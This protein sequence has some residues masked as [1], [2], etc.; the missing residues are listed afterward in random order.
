MPR[1]PSHLASLP[2]KVVF[3]EPCSPES[4]TTVGRCGD[5]ARV[6]GERPRSLIRGEALQHLLAHGPGLDLGDKVFRH[7]HLDVGLEQRSA[8]LTQALPDVVRAQTAL[9]SQVAEDA[10]EPARERFEHR[11]P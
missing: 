5:P 7:R 2:A 9:A 3:P 6:T 8:D 11:T 4:T 1:S 10:F